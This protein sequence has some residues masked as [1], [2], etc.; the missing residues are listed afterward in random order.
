MSE[1]ACDNAPRTSPL[2]GL[3]WKNAPVRLD[4]GNL[5][6]LP[7]VWG[8]LAADY[9]LFVPF[10][11]PIGMPP[12]PNP[13]WNARFHPAAQVGLSPLTTGAPLFFGPVGN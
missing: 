10:I 4:G 8:G 13:A 2:H 6:L 11:A 5:P 12:N 1:W 9:G 3:C 7:E